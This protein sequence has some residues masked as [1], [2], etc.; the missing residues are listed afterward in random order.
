MCIE[1]ISGEVGPIY[2]AVHNFNITEPM[3][4]ISHSYYC[5]VRSFGEAVPVNIVRFD[6]VYRAKPGLLSAVQNISG[7]VLEVKNGL[8]L[9]I[10]EIVG[11]RRPL[12]VVW[13]RDY[14]VTGQFVEYAQR[15]V[16]VGVSEEIL[17]IANE[18]EFFINDGVINYRATLVD[19]L[20]VQFVFTYEI[21]Y[22]GVYLSEPCFLPGTMIDVYNENDQLVSVAVENLAVGSWIPS[23]D[24]ARV[25][26]KRILSRSVVLQ[27]GNVHSLGGGVNIFK[28][29]VVSDNGYLYNYINN[30][31]GGF[32]GGN[33]IVYQIETPNYLKYDIL[34]GGKYIKSYGNHDDSL[35]YDGGLGGYVTINP[36][37]DLPV[38]EDGDVII[39]RK[40]LYLG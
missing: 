39:P 4:D 35:L 1:L 26:V 16:G 18:R 31:I 8:Q 34:L 37:R 6:V 23:N 10:Q 12:T 19:G 22:K 24:G 14:P 25:K 32:N 38:V 11:G 36:F 21:V 17:E 40:P 33:V 5:R 20:G 2:L 27:E 13:E 29:A 3:L 28:S 30:S 7:G 9:K 15:F